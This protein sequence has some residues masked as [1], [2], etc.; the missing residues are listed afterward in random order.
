MAI[1]RRVYFRSAILSLAFLGIAGMAGL[2]AASQAA[3]PNDILPEYHNTEVTTLTEDSETVRLALGAGWDD[4]LACRSIAGYLTPWTGQKP[5]EE[6]DA[7]VKRGTRMYELVKCVDDGIESV[8]LARD[9]RDE[10]RLLED[11][12]FWRNELALAAKEVATYTQTAGKLKEKLQAQLIEQAAKKGISAVQIAPIP[13]PDAER[14]AW[15]MAGPMTGVRLPLNPAADALPHIWNDNLSLAPGYLVGKLHSAGEN[16]FSS[17]LPIGAWGYNCTGKGQYDWKNFDRSVQMVRDRGGKF[18]LEL[19][20]LTAI[21]TDQQWGAEKYELGKQKQWILP[22]Y[23]PALPKYLEMDASAGLAA[24]NKDGTIHPFGGVQLFNPAIAAEYA[25]YLK[26]MVANL[27][28]EGLYDAIAA[29]HLEQG[30]ATVLGDGADYSDLTKQRWQAYLTK[31]Y[32]TIEKLNA[33]AGTSAKSFAEI[34]LPDC[35][36]PKAG[37]PPVLQVDYLHFRRVWVRDY[38]AIKRQLIAAAFPDKLLITEMRQFSDHD[39]ISNNG[40]AKWGGF[41]GKT[42]D[43]AQWTN[44]GAENDQQPFMIRSVGPV[45]FGTRPSDSIESLFRDYL[46]INFRDPGNLTRYFYDW[47]AHGYMDEQLG[48]HSVGNHWLTD[49]LI[50]KLGTTVANTAPQPQR[51]GLLLPRTTFDLSEGTIYHEYLG[52]DWLLNA[53]KLSYTRI[54]ERFIREGG[55]KKIHLD[56]LVLPDA[57]AMDAAL[58]AE[59]ARWTSEGGLLIA[60]Q[61]PAKMDEYG[62]KL[63]KS[64]LADVLDADADGTTSEAVTKTPLTITIPKGIFTGGDPKSTDRKPPFT[65]LKPGLAKVLAS[66]E[67]GKPAITS[68]TYGKGQGVLMGYPFGVEAV[69]ADRTSITF[70]RTY[71]G[72]VREPQLVARTAWLRQFIVD[73]LGYQ[74]DYA[75]ESADV[76]R[77][78]GKEAN[79]MGLSVPKGMSQE[80][81]DWYY[82]TTVGDPRPSHEIE[83]DHETPDMALRFFP[84]QR[85][86]VATMYLGIST[87]EVHYIS[88]RGA[89]DMLLSKHSYTCRIN[90]PKIQAIWDVARNVPVGFERDATGVR[91]TISLP[92]G[93]IMMLA[94]SE[95]PVVQMFAPAAFPG[96]EKNAVVA[97]CVKLAGEAKPSPEV[98]NLTP[99]QIG[100]WLKGLAESKQSVLI[101]Y[102][103]PLNKATAE[104]L[105]AVL[106]EQLQLNVSTAEQTART[107]DEDPTHTEHWADA[108]ILIGDEWT[109][110]DLALAGAY[111][112]W[113]N[114]YGPHLPFT[115]TYAWPGKGRTVVSLSRRYALITN[116]GWQVGGGRVG[117]EYR[118]L[119]VKDSYGSLRR[120]LY[121]AGNGDDAV[122]AVGAVIDEIATTKK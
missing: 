19:P 39:G 88:P 51:I 115:A 37:P 56:A 31:Q 99:G 35:G 114:H 78:K 54:D 81:S 66:Y 69:Q 2:Q 27:K 97:D 10:P 18:L 89:V 48:W 107:K 117:A 102:G 121:I 119:P 122:K 13:W 15:R 46:W 57:H 76:E 73:Q 16:F 84:R 87:R 120:K 103:D 101:C 79:A 90:N 116:Q 86:G 41:Q 43:L 29:V 93:H 106:R 44:V 8:R 83:L 30:D 65:V 105:A 111:W 25:A 24:R 108:T 47:V 23:A 59:I 63:N 14:E 36:F 80:A 118:V 45:G 55:L 33:N 7:L 52:W 112:N 110:N 91:F 26:A 62:R 77:F 67:S 68:N 32:G 49:Q 50:Y 100:P 61:V 113:G 74:P 104:K 38:L 72:F 64:L 71:S 1:H 17:E 82:V 20:T 75:V 4:A 12:A 70:Y 92:S 94:L 98:S 40:E 95:T 3:A 6:I 9:S 96:R 34:E 22:L 58:A 28:Q 85:A 109:N 5:A 21:K 42:D 11:V 53:S 60:S